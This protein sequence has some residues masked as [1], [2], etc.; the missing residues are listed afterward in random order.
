VVSRVSEPVILLLQGPP[1]IFWCELA[2]AFEAVGVKTRHVNFS[3]G[4]QVFWPKRG[5][6]NFRKPLSEWPAYLTELIV[7]ENVTDILYYA[8]Q[9]PYHLVAAD[10][11]K[12]LG[13]TCHAI[14]YGYLRPDWITLERGGMGRLSHFP[15][16]PAQISAIARQV[17][18][19][20]LVVR[21][22]HTFFQESANEVLY[23]LA[24]YFG[25]LF[26][27]GY[28]SDKYYDPFFEYL[29]WLPR[30]FRKSKTLPADYTNA[31]RPPFYLLALQLQSDYQIRA[32]SPYSHL[33]EMIDEVIQSFA[34]HAPASARLLVKQHPLDNGLEK[35][36]KVVPRI[37]ARHG[38]AERVDFIEQGNVGTLLHTASGVIVVNSTLG[39][40]SIKVGCPTIAL[41]SAIY[42]IEGLTHQGG[43]ASFWGNPSPVDTSLRDDYIKALAASVQVKGDFYNRDGRKVAIA[44][45]VQRI[46]SGVVNC[47]DAFVEV[48]PRLDGKPKR[49]HEI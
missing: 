23:N 3:L 31:D 16:Q 7:K 36:E 25:R 24:A 34:A 41:G 32:N 8:D 14:E 9:L 35:W 30:F 44:E 40:H 21:Y 49:S 47:P 12:R 20:D 28:Q 43:L 29:M 1:S 45:I 4:D 33:S 19:A 2:K 37:A 18:P 10:V 46:L 11:A 22:P 42:D 26:F 17:G 27:P 13:V 5:A 39:L 15:N 48:P 38:V 6:L